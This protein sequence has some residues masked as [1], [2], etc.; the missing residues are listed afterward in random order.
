L[1]IIPRAL[2]QLFWD[3]TNNRLGIGT[4]GPINKFH[5]TGAI[6]SEG[7]LNSDG[8][9]SVPSYRFSG[10][11]NTGMFWSAADEL[12][13]SVGGQAALTLRQTIATGL[14]VIANGSLELEE[15]LIDETGN[16]GTVGQVLTATTTG[17]VWAEP[18]VVAMGKANGANAINV[19]GASISGGVG[20]NTVNLT[21]ARPNNDYIIQLTVSGDNRIYVTNQTAGSFTVEIRNSGTN[22]LVVA[23]WYFTVLDF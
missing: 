10:D 12:G 18:A 2:Q 13:F 1:Q 16:A 23:E 7:I 15:Q 8:T 14:E 5:V 11:I 21:N 19:N 22:N 9:V 17:T 6:R 4:N 20:S 3:A